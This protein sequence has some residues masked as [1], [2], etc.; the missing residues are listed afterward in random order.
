MPPS[1]NYKWETGG[2]VIKAWI[3][4][5]AVD[6]VSVLIVNLLKWIKLLYFLNLQLNKLAWIK[7]RGI[8]QLQ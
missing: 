2:I 6:A 8:V 7:Y 1:C 3:S 5:L 4:K